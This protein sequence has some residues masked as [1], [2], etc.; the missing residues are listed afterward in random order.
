MEALQEKP[1]VLPVTE[2]EVTKLFPKTNSPTK[3]LYGVQGT[4]NGHISRAAAMNKAL[5]R[6]G[7]YDVT[8]VMSGRPQQKLMCCESYQWY[9][10]MTFA[11]SNGKI[12]L[13]STLT[14]INLPQF[15]RDIR[16]ISLDDY[17][18]IITDFEPVIAWSAKKQGRKTLGI[19][20]QYAF[21][22]PMPVVGKNLIPKLAMKYLAPA[23]IKIGLHWHHFDQPVLPPIVDMHSVSL[24]QQ[25]V[26][27]KVLVY[28]PFENQDELIKMLSGISG[29]NFYIYCAGMEKFNLG[30]IHTRAISKTGFKN[31]LVTASALIT[32]S[33]FEL[34]SESLT[35]GKKILTKPLYGQ[36]EQLCNA[37]ALSELGYA[38]VINKL[39]AKTVL[40]WLE[41]TT[42]VYR[43]NYPDVSMAIAIWLEKRDQVSVEV[44]SKALWKQ[45]SVEKVS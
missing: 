29:W 42:A 9:R 23:D 41:S 6:L 36:V 13:F 14:G 34:I 1:H 18:L 5:S 37:K 8:W 38:T 30:N 19:G 44:L 43:V 7:G 45:T 17:E 25:Q 22:Y 31:D 10:G 28:L 4:G 11:A 3:V 40:N 26:A 39:N 16:E 33:G 21:Y 32:N 27:D 20:H 12:Q 35:L 24:D 15:F 2:T